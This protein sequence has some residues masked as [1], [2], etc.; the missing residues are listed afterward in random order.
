MSNSPLTPHPTIAVLGCGWLGLPLAKALVAEGYSVAGTTTTPTRVLTLRDASI[1]PYLLSLGGKFTATDRDTLHTL[2]SGTETL[3][4]NV[5]P[6]RG[7]T[8]GSYVDLLRP[9]AQ[10]VSTCQVKQV[11]FVSSTS[12]YADEPRA[13]RETD[14]QASPDAASDILRAEDLFAPQ[15]N[16]QDQERNTVVRLGGL[17]GPQR[18]PGR[19]LAGRHDVA[20]A[21]APVNLIHLA[22]CV[23]L[24]SAIIRKQAWGYTFN[25]CALSHPVRSDFY[26]KAARQLG[27]K[28]PG[29]RLDDSLGGKIIDSTLIRQT[30]DY[31]FQHDDLEA[32]LTAC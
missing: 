30:L 4:L 23:G 27:L 15:T 6:R 25:A 20:Q 17:F 28:P 7:T 12:V 21:S 19:F 22:D 26:S 1:R 18:P 24:L 9:V 16:G 10:A 8:T 11:L 32:A 5:P 31:H 2:L 29:F 3:V 14:A 13:M